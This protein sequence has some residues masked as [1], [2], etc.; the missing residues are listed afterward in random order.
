[1]EKTETETP[2]FHLGITMAGAVSAGSYTAGVMDYF[3][4][5]MDLWEN[6]KNGKLPEGWDKDILNF[7]PQ[8]KVILDVM[9]GTSAGG[10]TTMMSAIYALNGKINPVITPDDK[11]T[12]KNNLFYDSWVLMGQENY[13]ENYSLFEQTLATSDLEQSGKV[14]SLLNSDFIDNIC[15]R[16]F[17]DDIEQKYRPSY[18]SEELEII[19][20]NT[21]VRGIPLAVDFSTQGYKGHE[22]P[23]HA[24]FNHFITSHFKLNF[25][26]KDKDKYLRFDPFGPDVKALKLVT[27]A[28]GAFPIGLKFRE[29][30]DYELN[31]KYLKNNA[32][33]FITHKEN[34]KSEDLKW[35]QDFEDTFDF[36][37]I[38]G[39]AVNNEPYGEVLSVLRRKENKE[40]K[41]FN[42]ALIM[43]DPFPD[44]NKLP[45]FKKPN[46]VFDIIPSIID[47]LW[48]QSKVKKSEML[49][50]ISDNYYRGV[51]YPKR[52]KNVSGRF[53]SEEYPIACSGL[54]AFSGFFDFAF[55]QHDYFLGRNNARNFFRAYFNIEYNEEDPN[56]IHKSWSKEMIEKF[57]I[58]DKDG[59]NT[60]KV[61]NRIFLPIIPDL[62]HLKEI[63][64]DK[65]DGR[66]NRTIEKWPQF[67]PEC[68]FNLKSKM[69]RRIEKILDLSFHKLTKNN[70][71][72]EVPEVEVMIL[73]HYPVNKIFDLFTKMAIYIL[74]RVT[75]KPITRRLTKS[76]IEFILK[77]LATMGLLKKS[78]N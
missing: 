76:A 58:P 71:T 9:G 2:E 25:T 29:F 30:Y 7:I 56:P 62:N 23:M 51:I 6:A 78:N 74:F 27:K 36:V 17:D 15:D 44:E 5:I 57:Q 20:A 59:K 38:D 50:A 14:Q 47:T 8:H 31:V 60:E 35:P 1:M 37:S 53:I 3:F 63:L 55:R 68:L 32:K 28:T 69:E 33:K 46:D 41:H 12:K 26:D 48:Q 11:Y 16:I 18:I 65:T 4:E 13:A 21:S 54:M 75:K 49:D 64:A 70:S 39:G 77:D 52:W 24:T 42:Y 67:D 34:V 66:F 45:E 73:K 19:I 61:D 72:S 40:S 10:M 43:I 22:N